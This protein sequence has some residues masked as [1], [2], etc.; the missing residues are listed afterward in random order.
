MRALT[1]HAGSDCVRYVQQTI[2]EKTD[3]RKIQGHL[4]NAP[5]NRVDPLPRS[6]RGESF[7]I[8]T[9]KIER[10]DLG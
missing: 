3:L 1:W 2:H 8:D 7:S 9:Y 4:H 10:I 5:E 6:S